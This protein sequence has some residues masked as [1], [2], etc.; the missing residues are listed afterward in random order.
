MNLGAVRVE[1]DRVKTARKLL[2]AIEAGD[3]EALLNCY[4]HNAVQIEHPNRLKPNGD[5]RSPDAM[6]KDLARGKHMLR[7]EHYEVLEAIG[8][9]DRVAL[10]VKW[11][12][13]LGVPVGGLKAGDT[14]ICRSA[15]FLLF[16]GDKIA[17]QHNYDCFEP[18]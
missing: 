9:A 8:E 6:V 18:F 14:M 4:A 16:Q 3:G 12:G 10:R 2:A 7:E 5:R 13:I 1:N 11:T 15:V 17:E